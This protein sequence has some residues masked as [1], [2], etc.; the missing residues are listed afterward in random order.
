MESQGIVSVVIPAFNR[1]NFIDQ[2]VTSVVS[3]SYSYVETIVVDDGSTDGTWERL[4][5]LRQKHG[6]K[7]LTHEGRENRG[8]LLRLIWDCRRPSVSI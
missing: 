2:T 1:V 4:D 3:Q 8:S 6:I 5:D 7:V